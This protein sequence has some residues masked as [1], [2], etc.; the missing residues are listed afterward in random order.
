MCVYVREREVVKRIANNFLKITEQAESEGVRLK[1][2]RSTFIH[3]LVSDAS[4]G[5]QGWVVVGLGL[6]TKNSPGV[7]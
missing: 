7:V 1:G 6:L 3:L 2:K 4:G 5:F